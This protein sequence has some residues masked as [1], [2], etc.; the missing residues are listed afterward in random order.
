MTKQERYIRNNEAIKSKAI[1]KIFQNQKKAFA[2]LLENEEKKSRIFVKK[3]IIDDIIDPFLDDI[4]SEVPEYLLTVLPKIMR[5]GAKDPIKRYKDLLPD[6]YALVFNIST[7]PATVY[8]QELSDLML[9]QRDGSILKTTKDELRSIMRN[10]ISDWDSYTAI[11]K[12]IREVDPFVFSRSRSKT[13]AV[14]EIGRSYWWANHEPGNV[15]SDDGYILEKS[16]Q[17]SDDEKVRPTHNQ[18]EEAWSIPFDEAFPWTDDQYAPST[19]DINCRCTST[20]KIVG[21]KNWKSVFAIEKW[22]TGRDIKK[23]FDFI[24]SRV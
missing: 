4:K 5:E 22:A 3:S 13:I 2:D 11:A 1:Y 17:S 18:N 15:L 19:N 14:N 21:I 20:H 9:S 10:G 12:R 16:W 23:V 24:K 6:D 7:A 8:L